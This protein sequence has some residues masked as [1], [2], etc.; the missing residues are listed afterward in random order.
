VW[1][2]KDRDDAMDFDELRPP[3]DPTLK[4]TL[5]RLV[6]GEAVNVSNVPTIG[7]DGLY[8]FNDLLAGDYVIRV[9]GGGW[10]RVTPSNPLPTVGGDVG[11]AY[12]ETRQTLIGV[13][14]S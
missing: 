6:D 9:S 11:L 5:A 8:D 2:D 12:A 7:D 4:M 3:F 10:R 13:R 1:N 14:K